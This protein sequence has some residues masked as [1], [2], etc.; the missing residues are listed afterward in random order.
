MED[1]RLGAILLE[2][3][4]VDEAGLERCL[5]I[6]SLTGGT[7]PVG[8]ILV[9]QGLLDEATLQRLLDLQR[10]RVAARAA[11]VTASGGSSTA[12]LESA[13]RNG[14]SELVVSEGRPARILVG[15]EWR[16]LTG[17]V[18]RGPE[19]WDFVRETMGTEVLE[20]LAEQHHVVRPWRQE[21]LGRGTA[22]GFRQFEG[23]AVRIAFAAEGQ[24][25]EQLGLTPAFV[26][27][28]GAVKGLLLVVGERGL[29]RGDV[30][31]PLTRMVAADASSYV[32]V[33]DDEPMELPQGGGLVVRRRYGATPEQRAQSLRNV[34][35]EDPDAVVIADVGSP[36]TF[37]IALRAAEGGR[38]VVAYLDACNTTAAL[39][40]ILNFYAAYDLSRIRSSLAAVLK[41]VLVRH[42]LPNVDHT[43]P[44]V[45]TELLVV[46][47][48]VRDV[49]RGGDI[50]DVSLL[51]RAEGGRSGHSLDRSMLDLL[52]AGRVRIED[53]F[54]RA[55]EKA[56]LLEKTRDLQT[57]P[58]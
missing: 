7:R 16:E 44:V 42:V 20:E 19:V 54:E 28:V 6:Q 32:V 10:S 13:R 21:G 34:V 40:R 57:T 4:V 30:L 41:A 33:V 24:T 45:A 36:E 2:G 35:R 55:E 47:D 29:G 46:D 51:L 43:G 8:Q 49:V 50:N 39:I 37:E 56:W 15:N 53:V 26:D 17:D 58:R 38:L 25:L 23:V 48:A 52:A 12:L 18:L 5:A 11:E 14:A 31:L 22:T 27:L 1:I 3:G 9:E